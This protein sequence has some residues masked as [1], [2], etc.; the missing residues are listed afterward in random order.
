VRTLNL[1]DG[2][3]RVVVRH[4]EHERLTL[5]MWGCDTKA[6]RTSRSIQGGR[7]FMTMTLAPR[8]RTADRLPGGIACR[9]LKIL[10]TAATGAA[11]VVQ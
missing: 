3:R 4:H 1:A 9:Y 10:N 7:S 2:R 11:G 6:V 5:Q 8:P